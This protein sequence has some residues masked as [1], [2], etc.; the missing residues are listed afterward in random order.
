MKNDPFVKSNS[1]K[2]IFEMLLATF[3][4]GSIPIFSIWCNLPSPIFVFFRVLFAVPLVLFYSIRNWAKT[5][6]LESDPLLHY[7]YLA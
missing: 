1:Q 3:I 5:N 6:F 7:S 4:W 2:G